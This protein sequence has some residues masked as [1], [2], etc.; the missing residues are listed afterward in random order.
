MDLRPQV[1]GK[2]R[3][4]YT[5]DTLFGP[6]ARHA[7]CQVSVQHKPDRLVLKVFQPLPDDLHAAKTVVFALEGR[8]TSGVVRG[9]Q[10]L[11]D[12]SLRLEL[13]TQ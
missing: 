9:R 7:E 11:S 8:R 1:N 5:Q 6:L 10:R 3:I 13:E 4:D 2:A 12:H